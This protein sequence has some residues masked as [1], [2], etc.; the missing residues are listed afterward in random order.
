MANEKN[1]ACNVEALLF[2]EKNASVLVNL[3]HIA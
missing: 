3:K 2:V 1:V